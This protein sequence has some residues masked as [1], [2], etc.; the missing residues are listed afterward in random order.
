MREA[1]TQRQRL[2]ITLRS[3]A[4]GNN[5]EAPKFLRVTSQ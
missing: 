2:S 1:V 4:T 3:L 5:F